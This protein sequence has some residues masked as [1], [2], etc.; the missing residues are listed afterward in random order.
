MISQRPDKGNIKDRRQNRRSGPPPPAFLLRMRQFTDRMIARH[1]QSSLAGLFVAVLGVASCMG[2]WWSLTHR[3]SLLDAISAD[4]VRYLKL[5]EDVERLQGRSMVE[6]ITDLRQHVAEAEKNILNGYRPIADFLLEQ[7][8]LAASAGL[9]F[10]YRLLPEQDVSEIDNTRSVPVILDLTIPGEI[11][12]NGFAKLLA[13]SR[14]L[15]AINWRQN[16]I[17]ME[18]TG[19]G[20][21]AQ[22]MSL[23]TELWFRTDEPLNS[24]ASKVAGFTINHEGVGL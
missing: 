6:K 12:V 3:I 11:K 20:E 18:I 4:T 13:F 8:V 16:L 22:K 14:H 2:V 17:S 24:G 7:D 5:A 9:D 15:Q 10:S 19:D 21:G 1:L 23:Q